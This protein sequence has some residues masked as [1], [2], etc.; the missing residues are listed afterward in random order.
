MREQKNLTA[1]QVAQND[2]RFTTP[3]LSALENGKINATL[4]IVRRLSLAT[5]APAKDFF[6]FQ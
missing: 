5:G 4:D 1:T 3:Y 2:G 6:D